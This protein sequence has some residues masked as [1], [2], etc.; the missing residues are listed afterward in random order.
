M[1]RILL[2]LVLATAPLARAADPTPLIHAHAHN[3]YEHPRPLFD[4]LDHGFTSIEADIHLVPS[5]NGPQLL[6]AHDRKH[7][8]PRRTLQSLYLDP[9]RD[10]VN[11]NG[12]RVYKD[13]PTVLLWIDIKTEAH[14]T[15]AALRDVLKPY[16]PML[17]TFRRPGE[18]GPGT[19]TI[20]LR[21]VTVI[22][23]GNRIKSLIADEPTR[24]T[25][26]DGLPED[27]DLTPA[28]PP[29]LVPVISAQWRKLFA[30]RGEGPLREADRTK[31]RQLVDKAHA[32]KRRIRFW[33]APD[34]VE[35]WKTLRAAGV[36]LLNTD[37]LAGCEAFLLAQGHEWRAPAGK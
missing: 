17:T 9:L 19:T 18:G 24:C 22:I 13:G 1:P 26:Y 16:E 14:A 10:C 27:L 32:Q 2:A 25:T 11:A 20:D 15:Y 3:D 12:G 5:A 36:D 8:D 7:L 28:D 6:V 34:N 30:W 23:T 4:A 21:A 29:D 35:G 31:L 33:D 37:D